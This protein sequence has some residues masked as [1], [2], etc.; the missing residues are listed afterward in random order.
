MQE[1]TGRGTGSTWKV[2][3]H[4]RCSLALTLAV[5]LAAPLSAAAGPA[6]AACSPSSVGR[7]AWSLGVSG[8]AFCRG[9]RVDLSFLGVGGARAGLDSALE[10]LEG[11]SKRRLSS[12]QANLCR[13][14]CRDRAVGRSEG[15][16]A[17]HSLARP[18]AGQ[19]VSARCLRAGFRVQQLY[20]WTL[21][22]SAARHSLARPWAGTSQSVPDA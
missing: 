6:A 4:Q 16:A 21:K 1:G 14:R 7:A 3:Q 18:W 22:G 20:A 11:R 5:N 12:A 13:A 8:L 9:F 19:P 10:A 17:R 2:Q 15:S